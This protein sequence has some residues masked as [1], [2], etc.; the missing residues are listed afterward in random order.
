MET[1]IVAVPV[2]VRSSVKDILSDHEVRVT[3]SVPVIE[4]VFVWA[5][6]A[7]MSVTECWAV[8]DFV[9]LAV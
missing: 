1:E 9:R 6:V 2:R 7:V 3:V 8:I 4:P 5:I